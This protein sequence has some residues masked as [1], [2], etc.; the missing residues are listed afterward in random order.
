MSEN[1][2]SEIHNYDGIEEQ[3]NPMPDW[4]I[5]LFILCVIFAFIY[6]LHYQFGGGQTQREEYE[7]AMARFTEEIKNGSGPAQAETE[8]SLMAYMKNENA[9]RNG[10]ELYLGK[11]AM[12]HGENLEGK[13]GP[14]L[15]DDYWTTGN[16]SRVAIIHVISKGST[17]KGMPPWESMLKPNEIKNV[18]AFI[19][20]NLGSNPQNAKAPEGTQ[21]KN[22]GP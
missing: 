17:E 21:I 2:Q 11:C 22:T 8:E 14:N 12:C 6:W 20:S 9:I 19:Y 4:W 16:G 10:A 18:A 5:W 3:N 13:I 15:T 7:N 1:D